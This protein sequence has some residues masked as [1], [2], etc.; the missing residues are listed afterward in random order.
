MAKQPTSFPRE[1]VRIMLLENVSETALNE[2]R[3]H[4]YTNID[5]HEKA[6]GEDDLCDA[7]KGVHV[8]GIRSKTQITKKVL[9]CADKLL[10]I[11]CFCIGTNQ[12]DIEA[13]RKRGVAV[14]NAPYSNTRSVAELV[15]GLIIMLIRRIP[16]KNRAAHEGTW[17]KEAS[18]SYELR[19][20]TLGIIGYGNIG[21]QVS[22]LAE[23]F[24][25]NV[26]YYDVITKLPHGNA[27]PV[28]NLTELLNTS[29]IITLHVPSTPETKNMIDRNAFS[30]IKPGALLVNYSRGDVVDLEALSNALDNKVITGAAIDVFPEEPKKK[31][32]EFTTVLQ[33]KSNVIL[34]PHIG[35]STLEA[36]ESIGL[37]AAAKLIAYL[38]LGTTTGSLTVPE[39]SLSQQMDT[40]RI[41]HIHENVPGVLTD[42][43]AD[44]SEHGINVVGQYLKTNEDI[45]YVILDIDR[46]ISQKAYEILKNVN[47][48]IRTRIVY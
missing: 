18:G 44:L 40:H 21:T 11:G 46:D 9:D 48:T 27:N 32:E 23:A 28:R 13:A 33:D 10:A 30:K 42:I 26:Q 16:D 29:D 43:N 24:G 47:G 39:V 2:F 4:G 12:V 5:F 1:K 45:G 38:E 31:G 37:D 6:L 35:G 25:M 7:I 8:I 36:Q 19:G 14:F 22:V 41:L 17:L 3:A 34:T 15:M 20:K